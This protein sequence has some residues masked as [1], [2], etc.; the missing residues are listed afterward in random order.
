MVE[1]VRQELAIHL[2]LEHPS[3]VQLYTC[4]ED[5]AYIY[6]AL[7]LCPNGDLFSELKSR[8]KPFSEKQG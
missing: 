5:D 1:R 3:I 6:L 2:Q 8:S 4:F 7:E